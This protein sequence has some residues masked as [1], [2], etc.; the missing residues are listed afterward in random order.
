MST[1]FSENNEECGSLAS[2]EKPVFSC[3][4]LALITLGGTIGENDSGNVDIQQPPGPANSNRGSR[5]FD[6]DPISEDPFDDPW[7]GSRG[8]GG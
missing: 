1:E 6:D 2:Y 8:G 3:V 4:P 7:T 5:D